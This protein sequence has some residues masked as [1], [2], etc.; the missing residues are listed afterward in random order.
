MPLVFGCLYIGQDDW[1]LLIVFLTLEDAICKIIRQ[2]RMKAK[3]TF[4]NISYKSDRYKTR[5]SG[6]YL[7][8]IFIYRSLLTR[9]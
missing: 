5:P 8:Y 1:L 7:A 2:F 4:E 9:L 6:T 3:K